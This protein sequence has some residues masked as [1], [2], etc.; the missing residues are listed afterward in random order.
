MIVVRSAF[1]TVTSLNTIEMFMTQDV[2]IRYNSNRIH[3][4]VISLKLVYDH[5]D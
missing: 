1:F 2:L 4:G 3:H 5:N